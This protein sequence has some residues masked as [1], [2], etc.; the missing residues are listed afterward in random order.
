MRM[1]KSIYLC[2]LCTFLSC[3]SWAQ[4]SGKTLKISEPSLIPVRTSEAFIAWQRVATIMGIPLSEIDS[5]AERSKFSQNGTYYIFE[6]MPKLRFGF[7]ALTRDVEIRDN[8]FVKDMKVED[9]AA[10]SKRWF[11]ADKLDQMTMEYKNRVY[12]Y[13]V[14]LNSKKLNTKLSLNANVFEDDPKT[15][16]MTGYVGNANVAHAL[17]SQLSELGIQ[18][19]NRCSINVL[20]D[21]RQLVGVDYKVR[22]IS[23]E[24][25]IIYDRQHA[26]ALARW[27]VSDEKKIPV[28]LKLSYQFNEAQK[29]YFPTYNYEEPRPIIDEDSWLHQRL[30]WRFQFEFTNITIDAM[31]GRPVGNFFPTPTKLSDSENKIFGMS[32]PVS[33]TKP[34]KIPQDIT[35][36]ETADVNF[37]GDE[38]ISSKDLHYPPIVRDNSPLILSEYF[39]KF[40]INF[41]NDGDVINLIGQLKGEHKA[42]LKLGERKYTFDEHELELPTPPVKIN[43]RIYLPA[44]LLQQ[45]N[46]VLIRW[47]PKKKLLWVD[48][49]YLRR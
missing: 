3:T 41:K 33:I 42:T 20:R 30:T 25:S 14:L 32:V 23:D 11:P 48:T 17:Y 49:R 21:K 29:K 36:V 18:T 1:F 6:P 43:G 7:D 10:Q 35:I 15:G 2:A 26:L 40:L 24:T 19:L 28:P 37:N 12:P 16:V 45:L 27:F 13:P 47:E 22:S 38:I 39:L 4:S 9:V 31:T 34:E 44:E 46:G 5:P 8:R